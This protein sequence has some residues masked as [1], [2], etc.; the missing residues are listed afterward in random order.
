MYAGHTDAMGNIQLLKDHLEAVSSLAGEFA[1]SFGFEEIAGLLGLCHDL[2]KYSDAAQNRLLRGGPRV[3]HTSAGALEAARLLRNN[4]FAY[5]VF[6]H[7]GGLMDGD[8]AQRASKRIPF[9]ARLKGTPLDYS[10]FRSEITLPSVTAEP[11]FRPLGQY[12]FSMSFLLRMLLSCIVDADFIDTEAFM[13]GGSV[14]RGGYASI[15]ALAARFQAHRESMKFRDSPINQKRDSILRDC[16]RAAEDGRGLYSLTV[17]TGGGKTLSSLAFALRH[18]QK[19]GMQR[20]IYVI[21]YTSIIEQTAA[22]FADILGR[23]NVLEHHA[24][25][26]YDNED[27]IGRR[28]YLSTENWDAPIVVTTNVQFFESLFAARTSKCRKLH[29]IAN[30]VVIFDEAQM[31]PLPYLQPCVRAIAELVHNYCST[32]V[33]CTATQPALD[34]IFP[35]EL[36]RKEIIRDPAELFSF[37]RRTQIR[38]VGAWEDAQIAETLREQSQALCIVSTRKQ[39]QNLYS[40]LESEGTYHLSTLMFPEHRKAVLKEI[41]QRL[42]EGQECRVVA[43][44]LIEAGVDVDFPVVYRA[45][46]GLDSIIQAAGRC[47][48]EGKNSLESSEVIVFEPSA[49]YFIPES[50]RQLISAMKI[51]AE[52]FEDVS[53][54]EAIRAYFT[55]VY[56]LRGE[57]LDEKQ[58]VPRFEEGMKSQGFPFAAIAGEFKLIESDTKTILIPKEEKSKEY[59]TRLRAGERARALLRDMGRY[60]VQVYDHDYKHLY[61]LGMI[62]VLDAEIAILCDM[63]IYEETTGLCLS[64]EGGRGLLV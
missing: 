32:A 29:N 15:E 3:D 11:P 53:T 48:R 20:V 28:L 45:L 16:L 30:S 55:Q 27:D 21:P 34:D 10:A 8:A 2:G 62:E 38:F 36:P 23:E 12:G 14:R 1:S 47:N 33:L 37:F 25:V 22:I 40:L 41:R 39:A 9:Q 42:K 5:P 4:L 57:L 60:S 56:T 31:I 17:P 61:E 46:A 24:A 64:A 18:A 6:A 51:V 50:Q 26:E 54:M 59:A 19:H 7:H 13:Q 43:T 44:S 35:P 49:D 58:V 63:A 52:R